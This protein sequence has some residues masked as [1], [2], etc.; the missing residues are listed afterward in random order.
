M[1]DKVKAKVR[2]KGERE[3]L[4]DY[5]APAICHI[6]WCFYQ[7]GAGQKYNLKPDKADLASHRDAIEAFKKNPRMTPAQNHDNWVKYRKSCGWKYGLVKDKKKKTHPDLVPFHMLTKV[8]QGKD[9]ADIEARRFSYQLSM[10]ISDFYY[11]ELKDYFK[12]CSKD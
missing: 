9:I 4:F 5:I 12:A 3:R 8:E 7:M 10:V 6:A 2:S 11:K 1:I